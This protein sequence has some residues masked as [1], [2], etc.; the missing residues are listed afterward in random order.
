[1][2]G[3]MSFRAIGLTLAFA[4]LTPAFA[5]T[6]AGIYAIVDE[7]TFEPT[8]REAE[9]IRIS[10]VFVVPV[11]VSSGLHQPPQHGYLY[12]SMNEEH[13]EAV[14]E[15]WRALQS[16]AGTGRVLGFGQY[17]VL[18]PH[19]AGPD[20]VMNTSLEVHVHEDGEAARPEPYPRPAD[21]GVLT[22][23]ENAEDLEPRFG[24]PTSEIV[25]ALER[26][27]RE[28][29][30]GPTGRA[31][32][33]PASCPVT[34]PGSSA[35][36]VPGQPS[37]EYRIWYGSPELAVLLPSDG[38]W[39]G[40][41]AKHHYRDK[42]WWWRRGYDPY[43]EPAPDLVI[44]ATRLDGDSPA[45]RLDKA[46]NGYG[47]GWSAMLTALEFPA[48]GCWQVNARYRQALLTF[49]VRVGDS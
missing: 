33:A 45:V 38:N 12:F 46:T 35:V 49:V 25:A 17:W 34:L 39:S 7:V 36:E 43:E 10:G 31:E 29:A 23:F 5:S 6:T 1:M 37:D 42:L 11:P 47:E 27:H 13:A 3:S 40:M 26:A 41:G 19:E 2:A 4:A 15:D 21:G 24:A 9:R 14:R 28:G 8:E 44:E 32:P 30:A 48:S 18:V 16:L 22:A 20:G